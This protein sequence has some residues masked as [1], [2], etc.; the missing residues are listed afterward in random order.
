MSLGGSAGKNQGSGGSHVHG[1]DAEKGIGALPGDFEQKKDLGKG[2]ADI[3]DRDGNPGLKK[4]QGS[5]N[6]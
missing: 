5:S 1:G 2:D 3:A 6:G 4:T